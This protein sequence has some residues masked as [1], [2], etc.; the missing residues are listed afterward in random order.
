MNPRLL[1]IHLSEV[2]DSYFAAMSRKKQSFVCLIDGCADLF[3]S[4]DNRD[5]HLILVHK[6]PVG[7]NSHFS[8]NL[9]VKKERSQKKQQKHVQMCKFLNTQ[10]GCRYGDKC[11]F[12][13]QLPIK[14]ANH[15]IK[16][17]KQNK[18]KVSDQSQNSTDALMNTENDY[19]INADFSAGNSNVHPVDCSMESNLSQSNKDIDKKSLKKSQNNLKAKNI[20]CDQLSSLMATFSGISI[21]SSEP[22]SNRRSKISLSK[23]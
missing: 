4:T 17:K 6:F 15:K 8:E 23:Y 2:H 20:E 19:N 22:I 14:T 5:D 7:F 13:H 10:E 1:D 16:Q 11:S 18:T 9:T 3:W 21:K 12:S